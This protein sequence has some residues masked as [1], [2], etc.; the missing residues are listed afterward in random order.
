MK[1]QD[2]LLG[3]YVRF[4]RGPFNRDRT[5]RIIAVHGMD[6]MGLPH[7]IAIQIVPSGTG[8]WVSPYDVTLVEPPY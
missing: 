2:S 5:Y 3:C 6:D 7:K 4:I 1:T 8:Y